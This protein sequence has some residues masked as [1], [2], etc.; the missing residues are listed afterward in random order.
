M[1][2]HSRSSLSFPF[3]PFQELTLLAA[4]YSAS[5]PIPGT[6]WLLGK[7]KQKISSSS[8][9]Q[10]LSIFLQLR[11]LQLKPLTDIPR[12]LWFLSPFFPPSVWLDGAKKPFS[13]EREK[14]RRRRNVR[15][16]GVKKSGHHWTI[17][18]SF[19]KV[20]KISLDFFKAKCEFPQLLC[21][22]V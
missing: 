19:Q 10:N 7:G 15:G 16:P 14:G 9:T 1:T 11:A 17:W 22:R 8:Q 6:D 18:K 20:A 21:W 3:S 2:N 12:S 5:G 4:H 13:T